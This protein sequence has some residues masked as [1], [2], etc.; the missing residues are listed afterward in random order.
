MP[1]RAPRGVTAIEIIVVLGVLA[2]LAAIGLPFTGS[3]G[4]RNDIFAAE[5]GLIHA[6]RRAQF[7]A[8][9]SEGG[10]NVWVRVVSGTGTDYIVY[11]G[12]SYAARDQDTE[13]VYAFPDTVGVAFSF[14]GATSTLDLKFSRYDGRPSAT[15]TFRLFSNVG[16]TS[17]I[18]VGPQGQVTEL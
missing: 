12:A 6:L 11:R 15:G 13:D 3:F 8:M 4:Q 16:G 2:L 14:T 7:R 5:R 1:G 18:Q 9:L 10:S 17:T